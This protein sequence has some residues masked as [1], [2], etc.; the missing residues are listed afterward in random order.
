VTW[1]AALGVLLGAVF[2]FFMDFLEKQKQD[3]TLKENG[4]LESEAAAARERADVEERM[5]RANAQPS[6]PD[7]VIGRLRDGTA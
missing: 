5:R 1:S 6:S 2:R 7:D 4:R 3:Q